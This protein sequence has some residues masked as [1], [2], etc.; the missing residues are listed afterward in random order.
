MLIGLAVLVGGVAF[1]F[2][3]LQA[4]SY[5]ETQTVVRTTK[6]VAPYTAIKE[7]DVETVELPLAAIP[8]DAL[9]DI[10]EV[11]GKYVVT[12]LPPQTIVTK[13]MLAT[14]E[15]AGLAVP[16]TEKFPPDWRAV[17]LKATL[18]DVHVGDRVDVVGVRKKQQGDAEVVVVARGAEVL[19]VA[20]KEDGTQEGR[21][22]LAMPSAAAEQAILMEKTGDVDF[23][24]RPYDAG[25]GGAAQ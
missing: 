16:L 10:R 15:G 12:K 21:I 11:L 5:A 2:S 25:K 8:K 14:R 1:V 24:L 20:K 18:L 7:G 17:A 22:T 19:D 13:S 4:R 23:L 9:T 3:Q 6:E